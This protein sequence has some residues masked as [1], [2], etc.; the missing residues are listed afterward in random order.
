MELNGQMDIMEVT[1]ANAPAFAQDIARIHAS[2]YSA[3]HFSATFGP[4]KLRQYNLLLLQNSDISLVALE[5]GK[6]V[7][8]IISGPSVSR[9]V[10]QFTRE[11][12]MYLVGRLLRH[13]Q[14][15]WAKLHGK[16]SSILHKPVPSTAH[17]RLLSIATDPSTQSRGVGA[18]LIGALETRLTARG[19]KRYGLSVRMDNPRAVEF[20]QRNGFAVEKEQLGSL[21][22]AKDLA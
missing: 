21:Y 17:Y 4:E 9:G 15:L 22:Y 11:N 3:A 20:Y 19:V 10:R 5:D 8:F 14:F 18:A 7:G 2:A 12:R 13:P 16:L 6:P 1:A